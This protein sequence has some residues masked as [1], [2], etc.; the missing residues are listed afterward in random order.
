MRIFRYDG[1]YYPIIGVKFLWENRNHKIAY[2]KKLGGYTGFWSFLP[3]IGIKCKLKNPD[4]PYKQFVIDAIRNHKQM[5]I[6]KWYY[7]EEHPENGYM[8][9]VRTTDGSYIGD[10]DMAYSLVWL[11]Y[12]ASVNKMAC[13]GWSEEKQC[14]LGWSHRARCCFKKGDKVFE[15]NYG[16]D[17]TPYTQHGRKTIRNYS[18]AMKAALNFARYVS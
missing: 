5:K 6:H 18:D 16:N 1:F 8:W 14:A 3:Y 7:N 2:E 13:Y 17:F 4:K 12:I 11:T 9:T 15:E 10:I